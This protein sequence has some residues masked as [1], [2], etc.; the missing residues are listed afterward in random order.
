MSWLACPSARVAAAAVQ[1]TMVAEILKDALEVA[2]GPIADV[3]FAVV[4]EG[5]SLYGGA[6]GR[7]ASHGPPIF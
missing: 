7:L 5:R 3:E 2:A 6:A 4:A 1:K